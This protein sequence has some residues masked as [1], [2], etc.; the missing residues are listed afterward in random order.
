MHSK[1]VPQKIT[2]NDKYPFDFAMAN[3]TFKLYVPD[4]SVE[5]YRTDHNFQ[6]LGERIRPMSEFK[7]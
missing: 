2:A 6:T 1:E 4:G 5:K 7:D 3:L